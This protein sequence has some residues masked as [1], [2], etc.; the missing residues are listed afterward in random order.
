MYSYLHEVVE[1]RLTDCAVDFDQ[2]FS[3]I[4]T[5]LLVKNLFGTALEN[6]MKFA[7]NNVREKYWQ[8]SR[9]KSST[10]T[11]SFE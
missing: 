4:S 3:W 6:M 2:R 10:S 11:E 7:E 5:I 9:S 1:H 8:L